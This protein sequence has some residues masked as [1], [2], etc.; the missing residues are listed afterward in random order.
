MNIAH[1]LFSFETGG[2]ENLLV[3]ICNNWKQNDQILVCIVNKKVNSQLVKK[4]QAQKNIQYCCLNR[5]ES[6]EKIKYIKKLSNILNAFSPDVIHLH[7]NNIFKFLLPIKILHPTWK[8]ILH[9][10][11]TNIYKNLSP[12]DIF[13]HKVFLKRLIAISE[14]VRNEIVNFGGPKK[15]IRVLYNGVNSDKFHSPVKKD[16]DCKTVICV[17]RLVP[18]K[19]GQD[20][21]IKAM[22]IVNRKYSNVKCMIVGAAPS[23]KPEYRNELE[24]LIK[25][26]DLEQT[27]FLV[28]NSNNVPDLLAESDILVVPSRYEGF[29]ITVIEGMFAKIPVIASKIE[30]PKEI[31]KD[32]EYGFLFDVDDVKGLANLI[33]KMLEADNS[34]LVEKAYAYA[35]KNFEINNMIS[36]LRNIYME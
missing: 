11:D 21:L 22:K 16:Q 15:K 23:D 4:L 26:L 10:H 18:Q 24:L 29:G 9:I 1:I 33:V 30:G 17:A 35:I 25:E 12:I 32:N 28:G 13:L 14:S 8:L 36:Q 3:D 34:V 2:I 20:V 7:N 5:E 6:G 27:V 19:K 31:I